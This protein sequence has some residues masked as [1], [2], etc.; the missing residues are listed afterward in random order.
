MGAGCGDQ[1]LPLDL[2]AVACRIAILAVSLVRGESDMAAA[3]IVLLG[4]GT[5]AAVVK[6]NGSSAGAVLS[7]DSHLHDFAGMLLV[8]ASAGY[9]VM[10]APEWSFMVVVGALTLVLYCA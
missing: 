8:F 5:G 2:L 1:S 7:K 6:R 4:A 9:I 10:Q 3:G